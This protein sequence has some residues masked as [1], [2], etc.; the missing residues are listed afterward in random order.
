MI[1]A[2][3]RTLSTYDGIIWHYSAKD[4]DDTSHY[5]GAGDYSQLYNAMIHPLLNMTIKGVLWY[6][7][8]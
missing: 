5:R 3:I 6:Q 1:N 2:R 4:E 7:G 8:E